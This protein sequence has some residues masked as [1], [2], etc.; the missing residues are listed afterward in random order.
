MRSSVVQHLFSL[1]ACLQVVVGLTPPK[2][3]PPPDEEISE[4][5]LAAIADPDQPQNG[6]TSFAQFID[7][8]NPDFGTFD[9]TYWY[10]ATY[11]KGPGSPVVLFTP[12][13]TA[14]TGYAS[15]LTDRGL[16]GM[17]AKEVGGAVVIIEHRYWG[18]STPFETQSTENLQYLTLDQAIAD[19]VHF[20]RTV[21]L[22]FDSNGTSNAPKAP[23]IWSGGS[24]SGALGAWIESLAPGTFWATHASSAPVQAIYDYWEYFDPVQ[25]GMPKNCSE[26]Y[27]AIIDYVDSVFTYGTQEEQADLKELFGLQDLAHLD[28]AA[29]TIS[30][31]IWSWQ[32][33]QFVSGYS[34]FFQMCDAIEG[35]TS[36]STTWSNSTNGIGVK[37]ALPNFA[38]WFKSQYL[39]KYC[40]GYGYEEWADPDS[41]ACFDTYN[42]A[43]PMFTDHSGSNSFG[44]TWEW[45]VC[46]E[47][48][49]YY[50]TGAPINRPTVFSRLVNAEYYQRQCDLFFPQEG[51]YTYGSALGKTSTDTNAHTKGWDLPDYLNT[52]SRIFW[53]N[54]EFDPWRSSSVASEFRPDGPLKN[55][56][57]A[58]SVVIP[59]AHH[60]N[61]LASSNAV[62]P[63]VKDTQDRVIKQMK[64]W[65]DEFHDYPV[66]RIRSYPPPRRLR[67]V[68]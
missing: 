27:S 34:S 52:T 14:A 41:V 46:N 63:G 19:F 23:W 38:K 55:T 37:K 64:T 49:F 11:W 18:N 8:D 6:V 5:L 29:S 43:S 31:P 65:V 67:S 28:D 3:Y 60:C 45:M 50:Q 61:D 4:D 36:N 54:G 24:Y 21:R 15:Y 25:Q 13:E 51:S 62:N 1:L 17:I 22:P 10:D 9:Q 57:T 2:P 26:D 16:P 48:L 42:A 59:G 44:R 33:I 68:F 53:V 35:V 66:R 7:H 39:P 12:G 30:S 47:P 56:A 40:S 20:A 32:G 58:P